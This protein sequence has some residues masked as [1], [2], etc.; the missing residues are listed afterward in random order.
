MFTEQHFKS[1]SEVF[2]AARAYIVTTQ[3]DNRDALG[4]ILNFETELKEVMVSTLSPKEEE[5][6]V[7]EDKQA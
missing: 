3:P 6:V 2:S 1:L 7:E 5:V 4:G